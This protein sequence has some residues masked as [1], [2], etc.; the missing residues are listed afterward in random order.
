[1]LLGSI[2]AI[3]CISWLPL[4]IFNLVADVFHFQNTQDLMVVYAVCHMMGMS[5]ACSNPVLYG[6]LN[7]NFWKE[8]TDILCSTGTAA[9]NG[10]D[11]RKLT[12]MLPSRKLFR[13]GKNDLVTVTTDHQGATVNTE[14]S[15]LTKC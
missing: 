1:M 13:R 15:M 12:V 5:S 10:A 11:C 3:F 6:C 7:E 9:D 2:A 8:F 14:M 4:D